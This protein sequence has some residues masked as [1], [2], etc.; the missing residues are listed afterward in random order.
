[1]INE[2]LDVVSFAKK[3]KDTKKFVSGATLVIKDEKGTVVKEF[4]TDGKVFSLEL[5]PG[6]YSLE[7]IAAPEGYVLSNEVIYFT[8]MEDG[9]LKVKNNKGEYADSVIVTFYNVKES[10]KEVEVPATDLDST[11]LIIGGITLL[12]GGIAYARKISQEC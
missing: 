11:M 9:T 7:E 10:E 6:E 8:L 1:M 2:L 5:N 4:I 3:D 12:I